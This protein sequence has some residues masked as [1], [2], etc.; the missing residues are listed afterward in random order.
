TEAILEPRTAAALDEHA[1]LE[2]RIAFLGDQ[3]THT[4]E[5][6]VGNLQCGFSGGN[7]VIHAGT[8]TSSWRRCRDRSR[9]I[10]GDAVLTGLRVA[11]PQRAGDAGPAIRLQRDRDAV[12][13]EAL[14]QRER[15][16]H[17]LEE[18]E[19]ERDAILAAGTGQMRPV[20]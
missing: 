6:G 11:P 3:L 15:A 10:D 1:Q 17:L 12:R 4:P 9:R 20:Q 8:S 14:G 5:R 7:D 19:G 16:L 2:R 13:D 18:L